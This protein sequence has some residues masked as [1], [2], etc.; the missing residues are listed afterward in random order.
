MVNT[1]EN[2]GVN[3]E[4]LVKHTVEK[5]APLWT[6]ENFIAV[7]PYW[8]K[9]DNSFEEAAKYYNKL[10]STQLTMPLS[11]YM[12]AIDE[13]VIKKVD[14]EKA[15]EQSG[16]DKLSA[17]EFLNIAHS[18]N[19]NKKAVQQNI[20]IA[21]DCAEKVSGIDWSAVMTDCITSWASSYF[22]KGVANWNTVERSGSLFHSWRKDAIHDKKPKILGLKKFNSTVKSL[23][24]DAIESIDFCLKELAPKNA[25]LEVYLHAL[26]SR[27]GGWAAYTAGLDWE[28][29][30]YG[31]NHA[32]LTDF[33]AVLLAWELS[34]QNSYEDQSFE[35][36]WEMSQVNN[37]E[38]I[39][40]F[41]NDESI[42]HRLILQNAYDLA[43]QRE[44]IVKLNSAD[45]ETS[46]PAEIR[47]VLQ[48]IFCID[49]RSEVYRRNLESLSPKIE[50]MGFAG[51]FAF[52]IHFIPLG[53]ETGRNQCPALIPSGAAV[54]EVIRDEKEHKKA[55][56]FRQIRAHL[57]SAWK[58]FRHSA[59]ACFG[60]VSPMG[61]TFLPKLFSDSFG[62]T[63]PVPEPQE[64]GLSK[65]NIANS[66]VSLKKEKHNGLDSGFSPED[67]VKLAMNA[68]R[69]MSLTKD[70]GKFVLITGHGSTSTNNPHA[71]GYDCGAC[72][73]NT[74]EANAK[75]AAEV[76][77]NSEVRQSLRNG[78]IFIPEDTVF[79]AAEHNTTT[80]EVKIFNLFDVPESLQEEY[81]E[82]TGWLESA[83][84]NTRSERA[85]RFAISQKKD[86][87]KIGNSVVA[88]SRDWAQT[89]P[90][91]GL[92]GCNTFV[93]AP[94]NRTKRIDLKG[95][96]F[97][98]S[99]N[100]REDNE[101]KVLELIMTAPMVVTNWINM[102]YFASTVDNKKFGSGNKTLHNVA[103][104]IG[105]L[106]GVAGDLRSG[107]PLQAIHDGEKW[108]HLPHRLNVVIEAPV[109]AI[110]EILEKHKTVRE[111]CDNKWLFLMIM[112]SDG[113]VSKIYDR[114]LIWEELNE[115]IFAERIMI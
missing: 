35:I 92:A 55:V 12:T 49:V 6:L 25:T 91:W 61:L 37:L 64:R 101:F 93:V 42:D 5:I 82:V 114:D 22:D 45:S 102:Q 100:W 90:E 76:L 48:A 4:Q 29:N 28:A 111:L 62:I 85:L 16:L 53:H 33:L 13:G 58:S 52:P 115:E 3:T 21:A 98:H 72:G 97:L 8:G 24:D 39:S 9:S 96:S 106:E 67:Q 2:I 31:G 40:D 66:T 50:T 86:A 77:N 109:E 59:V 73:G 17:R 108:Q 89:R 15:L 57:F 79:L 83:G 65:K 103:G 84:R 23:P 63:R 47:P 75:V 7:N 74:G 112:D 60:F 1:R 69:A 26:L 38:I 10:N 54:K 11:F 80:D 105:V 110:N 56:R 107:L 44:L 43:N 68:L 32:Q 78:G 51:F 99:Y 81:K 30:L 36:F 94:R 87:S 71:T 14:V 88:R 70:F 19:K 113:K 34:L 104:G 95:K 20:Q 46:K 18:N 41:K 27:V